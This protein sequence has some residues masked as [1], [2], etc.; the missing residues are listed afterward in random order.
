MAINKVVL[1][2]EV[3]LDLTADTV[4]ASHLATG[5]T[6]HNSAGELVTGTMSGGGSSDKTLFQGM[7]NKTITTVTADDLQGMTTLADSAFKGLTSLTSVAL[8]DSITTMGSSV[9]YGC[10]SLTSVALPDNLSTINYQD[11]Y[12][13]SSLASI[14][15]PENITDIGNYAFANCSSLPQIIIPDSVTSMGENAFSNCSSATSVSIGTGFP[16]LQNNTF[17]GC[18]SLTCVD[19]PANVV[20]L[21]YNVCRYCSN[22]EKIIMRYNGVVSR[23]SSPPFCDNDKLQGI[24][25]PAE[26]LS[27]YKSSSWSS[28]GDLIKP[29]GGVILDNLTD[30]YLYS[31][32]KTSVTITIPVYLSDTIPTNSITLDN[33]VSSNMF[34]ISNIVATKDSITFTVGMAG[35]T[36]NADGVYTT[37][38]VE[39]TN[40]G[41]TFTGSF[42]VYGYNTL[43]ELSYKVSTVTNAKYNFTLNDNGYYE[44]QNKGVNSS[45]A[46]CSV[47]IIGN[48]D[49][50][51]V[52]FDCINS[53]ESSCDFGILSEV[54]KELL[55]TNTIDTNGVKK[56]F[57]GLSSLNVQTV[58]YDNIGETGTIYVK[59]RKDGSGN[60]DNDS[61]QFKVRFE[62]D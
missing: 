56:S 14:N 35:Q 26:Q 3:Q 15:I 1:N 29:I 44:S 60:Q 30:Q 7:V 53:G 49:N 61:L 11:F 54:N 19:I 40:A 38:N 28:Y 5:Y 39:I 46:M 23:D 45:C 58:E 36:F 55:T 59:F 48:F 47:K 57:K 21:G 37:V 34:S 2:N 42:R 51:K 31:Y 25:V 24:Y 33:T 12:D 22:L 17:N 52:Y 27:A 8:P 18:S 6:A 13:C 32:K 9:F 16:R 10:S 4:D 62:E 20:S 50:K 41:N 43:P